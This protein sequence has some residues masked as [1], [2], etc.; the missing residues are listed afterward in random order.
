MR[1]LVFR[2]IG[3]ILLL[4]LIYKIFI[5]L[6]II[7][8]FLYIIK[9][10]IFYIKKYVLLPFLFIVI[11][12]CTLLFK[13]GNIPYINNEYEIKTINDYFLLIDKI[14]NLINKFNL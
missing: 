2:I 8:L 3:V 14:W 4:L 7:F 13:K 5:P 1:L 10:D 11:S 9:V 6:F 12:L